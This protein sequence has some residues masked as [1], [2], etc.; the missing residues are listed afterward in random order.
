MLDSM[1]FGRL[2]SSRYEHSHC[3]D[4]RTS[5]QIGISWHKSP[6]QQPTDDNDVITR[7]HLIKMAKKTD[8][9][10]ILQKANMCSS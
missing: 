10:K 9:Y 3:N 2:A 1:S 7:A 8:Q 4:K 6:G 5:N